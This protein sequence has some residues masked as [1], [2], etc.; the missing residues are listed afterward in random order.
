M[1]EGEGFEPPA[2]EGATVFKTIAI[3]HSVRFI[4]T[5]CQAHVVLRWSG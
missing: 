1:A 5:Y 4:C 3:V 2:P